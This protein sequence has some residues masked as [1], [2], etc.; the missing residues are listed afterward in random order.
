MSI[1]VRNDIFLQV[2]SVSISRQIFRNLHIV[3][4]L[5]Q[6]VHLAICRVDRLSVSYLISCDNEFNLK[7]KD[8]F[9]RLAFQQIL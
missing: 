7:Y 3:L 1:C 4:R 6:Q 9:I 8:T 2:T 5:Q